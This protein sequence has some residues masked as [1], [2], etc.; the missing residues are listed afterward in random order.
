MDSTAGF[1]HPDTW[2]WRKLSW[3]PCLAAFRLLPPH[4]SPAR[5]RNP[6]D[7]LSI[8]PLQPCLAWTLALSTSS[9]ASDKPII[10]KVPGATRKDNAPVE[11]LCFPTIFRPDP[12]GGACHMNMLWFD[13]HTGLFSLGF[14]HAHCKCQYFSFF[15]FNFYLS[16]VDLQCCVNFCCTAKWISYTVSTLL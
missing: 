16:I 10:P 11:V 8:P 13:P 4:S 3:D 5:V 1:T 6:A 14:L 9:L 15:F 7:G 2:F 12:G